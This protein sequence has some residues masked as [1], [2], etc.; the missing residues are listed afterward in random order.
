MKVNILQK[1]HSDKVSDGNIQLEC[2]ESGGL[3]RYG[4]QGD[5]VAGLLGTFLAWGNNAS[6]KG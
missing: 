5:V 6:K 2:S 1:G 4:G 3:R